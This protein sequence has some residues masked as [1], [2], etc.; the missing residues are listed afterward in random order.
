MENLA[1]LIARRQR[2]L[3]DCEQ[4]IKEDVAN[5]LTMADVVVARAGT[6]PG[7][8]RGGPV[9]WESGGGG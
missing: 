1:D 9:A 8:Y 4:H 3:Q 2:T 7:G 6:R 5:T